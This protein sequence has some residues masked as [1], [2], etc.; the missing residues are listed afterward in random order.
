MHPTSSGLQ[1]STPS[2]INPIRIDSEIIRGSNLNNLSVEM[3]RE[4]HLNTSDVTEDEKQL[5]LI[6]AIVKD[7]LEKSKKNLP[8]SKIGESI[9]ISEDIPEL[10]KMLKSS[11]ETFESSRNVKNIANTVVNNN[12]AVTDVVIP[13]DDIKQ[14]ADAT[15][16]DIDIAD[17]ELLASSDDLPDDILQDVV[18]LM[19]KNTAFQGKDSNSNMDMFVDTKSSTIQADSISTSN[20]TSD[21]NVNNTSILQNYK[22]VIK[23]N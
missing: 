5:D 15:V 16:D 9:I 14:L 6:D 2:S 18:E 8:I 1:L 10:V 22:V 21:L 19:E 4:M 3:P 11:E 23:L 12:N 17:I 7:E 13:E 20:N